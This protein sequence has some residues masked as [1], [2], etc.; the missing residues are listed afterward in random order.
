MLG[1]RDWTEVDVPVH[2]SALGKV[3]LAHGV[4]PIPTQPLQRLTGATLTSPDDLRR[5]GERTRR[6]G[7]ACTA[8]E[9]EVGLTGL[10]VPV[11]GHRGELVA[12]LGVSGPTPRLE[13]R[14]DELG[15]QLLDHAAQLST[16]LR[17]RTRKEGVA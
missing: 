1:T 2:C 14:L 10:A 7:W 6:R 3:F 9:L 11:H 16:L 5:D 13:G 12:A 4:V 17:G 8:D 15:A